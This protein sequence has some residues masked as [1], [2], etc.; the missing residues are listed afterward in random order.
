MKDDHYQIYE[1]ILLNME[2]G[3]EVYPCSATKAKK[4][5]RDARNQVLKLKESSKHY[6]AKI[7]LDSDLSMCTNP[8]L[9]T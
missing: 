5:V 6:L 3:M 1:Q 9:Y 8:I 4:I 7:K 2:K